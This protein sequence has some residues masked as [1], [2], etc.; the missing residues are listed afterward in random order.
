MPMSDD[1][2]RT[3]LL[4]NAARRAIRYLDGLDERPV[5]PT[6]DAVRSLS[7]LEAPVPEEPEQPS[8][9]VAMLDDVCSPATVATAGP[10]YFGY[11]I[12][13]SH[14]VPLAASWL[15]S[16]WDQNAAYADM[17]PAA[18]TIERVALAWLLDILHL[19]PDTGIG[20]VTGATMANFTCLAAA[21]HAILA[22]QHWDVEAQ[23]LF[24]APPIT[25]IVGDQV[26]VS[27]LK[28]L[29]L[30]GLGRDRVVRVPTDDQG[31]MRADALPALDAST[32]LCTQAGNVDSGAFDPFVPLC[33]AARRAGAWV[34]VDGAFG[35][36]A[37][38]A[39]GRRDL[40]HGIEHADS[41]AMDAHKW[42]NVPY[43][44]GVAFCRDA[45]SLRAAMAASAS[46]LV[47]E[48]RSDVRHGA[49]YTPELSR[50]ARGVEIWA[51]IASLGRNGIADLIERCCVL[52][53]RA[54]ERFRA[55]GVEVLNDV[56]LN[57]VLVRF[58][59]DETT[60][61]VIAGTQADGTCWC[62][63]TTWRGVAAMRMSVSSWKTTA[64]D[65]NRSVD[66]VL[67]VLRTIHQRESTT[68]VS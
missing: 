17:S 67:G 56:V 26:H 1:R 41:W 45:S 46:Y 29:S 53:A 30:L 60:R 64:D 19:P 12:G 62:G 6:V 50:R 49:H 63:G 48:R 3:N 52:A 14:E 36:W 38:A 28:A 33:D 68:A 39:P 4:E 27:V 51:A 66:A 15:A 54:A 47:G 35:L 59:D 24:G 23:G 55:A 58:G 18:A 5:A 32:V 16:A 61:A 10:R 7:T 22:R 31:R 44:S 43:D 25:I 65:I 21:R 20:F 40:V 8:R 57:Q 2:D 13:G 11:V 42:L 9:I 34:H 37:A